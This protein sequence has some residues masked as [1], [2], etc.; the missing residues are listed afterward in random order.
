MFKQEWVYQ[1]GVPL[2]LGEVFVFARHTFTPLL[3]A[4]GMTDQDWNA[5]YRIA[6]SAA[7]YSTMSVS[8]AACSS[9]HSSMGAKMRCT[10][11]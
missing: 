10:S 1:R 3:M 11:W 6:C 2:L 8:V 7:P 4:L 9:R 5:M